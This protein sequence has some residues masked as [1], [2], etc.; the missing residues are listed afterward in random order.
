[1]LTEDKKY[2]NKLEPTL[3]FLINV[4][5]IKFDGLELIW[6]QLLNI[7]DLE[8]ELLEFQNSVILRHKFINL[9]FELEKENCEFDCNT[10]NLFFIEWKRYKKL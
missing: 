5:K 3:Q 8:L 7:E 6:F 9:N 2:K 10:E 1:M 4:H